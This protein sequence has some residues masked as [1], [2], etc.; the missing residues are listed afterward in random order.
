[1]WGVGSIIS[2]VFY[3]SSRTVRICC[4]KSR[5][6]CARCLV[7]VRSGEL[8][9]WSCCPP[10]E[11]CAS[12]RFWKYFYEFLSPTGFGLFLFSISRF[13]NSDRSKVSRFFSLNR[14]IEQLD[15]EHV[16]SLHV[17]SFLELLSICRCHAE[18]VRVIFK[19]GAKTASVPSAATLLP[20]LVP[21]T[22]LEAS[23][24]LPSIERVQLFLRSA[25]FAQLSPS[26]QGLLLASCAHIRVLSQTAVSHLRGLD[27]AQTAFPYAITLQLID[28]MIVARAFEDALDALRLLR[29]N[30]RFQQPV[31]MLKEAKCLLHCGDADASL[32]LIKGVLQ[33]LPRHEEAKKLLVVAYTKL[34]RETE[35]AELAVQVTPRDLQV[36]RTRERKERHPAA[37]V[38]SQNPISE[39]AV[40]S[41]L[42]WTLP[43]LTPALALTVASEPQ[44][45]AGDLL[46]HREPF[47][48]VSLNSLPTTDLRAVF[49]QIQSNLS[50]GLLIEG[51]EL[52]CK[53]AER[54]LAQKFLSMKKSFV[55]PFCGSETLRREASRNRWTALPFRISA[56]AEW[57]AFESSAISLHEWTLVL[58][59]VAGLLRLAGRIDA[60][61]A[62]ANAA[63]Q[64][65]RDEKTLVAFNWLAADAAEELGDI[66]AACHHIRPVAV[67]HPTSK[68]VWNKAHALVYKSPTDAFQRFIVRQ[69]LQHP[70]SLP[71]LLIV[72]NRHLM[73]HS[74]FHAAARYIE[75]S[76]LAPTEPLVFLSA[77][78]A[79][80]RSVPNRKN[81]AR[82][83]IVIQAFAFLHRY[84]ELQGGRQSQ[85]ACYNLA[86]AF[87]ALDLT[88]QAIPL[89]L[90]VLRLADEQKA[91]R[92]GEVSSEGGLQREAA[93]N[94]SLIYRQQG[95]FAKARQLLVE[96]CSI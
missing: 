45:V 55:V 39:P 79:Q 7:P 62:L 6:R 61:Y 33:K 16:V 1:M 78:I 83:A 29:T 25:L 23:D 8:L 48:P 88:Y 72:G 65:F 41:A 36:F 3:Q 22:D 80:L 9:V 19:H 54:F 34:G 63:T 2:S 12:S 66:A 38:A 96:Y 4:S 32:P 93:Y 47:P 18:I 53:A 42:T 44:I 91:K 58:L 35:A 82:N 67:A 37:P 94:L 74:F 84:F 46:N 92:G 26:L 51:L 69:A 40:D 86:R 73:A 27:W 85:E 59:R 71:L 17:R 13:A 14:S 24:T 15:P 50:D 81:T 60:I 64:V 89:Y 28:A 43:K 77:G 52:G 31:F 20:K 87:H 56:D 76:V 30:T 95:A 10:S 11:L 21:E 57:T 70:E 68:R 5:R 75:A 49:K 90:D